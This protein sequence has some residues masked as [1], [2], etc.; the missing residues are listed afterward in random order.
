MKKLYNVRILV[1]VNGQKH[2][3]TRHMTAEVP[4]RGGDTLYEETH[5]VLSVEE[6]PQWQGFRGG[7][8]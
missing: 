3:R 8:V 6:V 1:D 4:P 7:V 2:I 5:T